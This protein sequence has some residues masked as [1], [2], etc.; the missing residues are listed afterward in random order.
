MTQQGDT[1]RSTAESIFQ[2][3]EEMIVLAELKPGMMYSEME[4]AQLVGAGRTPVREALQRLALEGLVNIIP[5]RGVQISE[6]D[7]D[8]QLQLLAV[9]RPIQNF[10]AEHAAKVATEADRQ[11]LQQFADQLS[12][13][14]N[15]TIPSRVEALAH[16]RTAHQLIVDAC[17]NPFVL[18]T[19][20][21][22]Q[23]L[24][25]RFWIYH[26]KPADYAP[27]A[28]VHA[29]L[30]RTVAAGDVAGSIAASNALIDY[31]E[32]FAKG[33]AHWD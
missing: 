15:Q 3:L 6:V 4:L 5:R 20:S 8:T 10:A 29:Q 17:H 31:L 2:Q 11:T 33:T 21:I 1:K 25:R 16:I 32:A 12:A 26:L 9:R 19:L 13:T 18:K 24:S 27:A 30:L 22:V 7:L 14:Q 23:G 28:E